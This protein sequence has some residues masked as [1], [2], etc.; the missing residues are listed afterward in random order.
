MTTA[1][2]LSRFRVIIHQHMIHRIIHDPNAKNFTDDQNEFQE[3]AK[4]YQSLQASADQNNEAR[5]KALEE[6]V[7]AGERAFKWEEAR[8]YRQELLELRHQ[9]L[10]PQSLKTLEVLETI[11][12]QKLYRYDADETWDFWPH[13]EHPFLTIAEAY[14]GNYGKDAPRYL[15]ARLRYMIRTTSPDEQFQ[16]YQENSNKLDPETHLVALGYLD[17]SGILGNKLRPVL[18]DLILG[19]FQDLKAPPERSIDLRYTIGATYEVFFNQRK[20]LCTLFDEAH[21]ITLRH[22]GEEH[23]QVCRWL[24]NM[25]DYELEHG[26]YGQGAIYAKRGAEIWLSFNE[27]LKAAYF[28]HRQGRMESR[29]NKPRRAISAFA[30]VFHYGNENLHRYAIYELEQIAA[31]PKGYRVRYLLQDPLSSD[32]AKE[33]LTKLSKYLD[34]LPTATELEEA[35]YN[36]FA[37]FMAYIKPLAEPDGGE[38]IYR[39]RLKAAAKADDPV[40]RLQSLS[41]LCDCL[42]AKEDYKPIKDLLYDEIARRALPGDAETYTDSFALQEKLLRRGTPEIVEAT[43]KFAVRFLEKMRALSPEDPKYVRGLNRVIG[44]LFDK[45]QLTYA[46]DLIEQVRRIAASFDSNPK[47]MDEVLSE[48]APYER[49]IKESS[50]H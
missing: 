36:R 41:D 42:L 21:Q 37:N 9:Y 28:F 33:A 40:S 46:I 11:C 31:H 12:D 25:L 47:E 35:N 1:N 20:L 4:A 23:P 13:E 8:Q 22:F 15:L 24:S 3:L 5:D 18:S 49:Y 50:D 7:A 39:A 44:E 2:L 48:V 16:W 43:Y 45:E 14:E 10:G 34:E 17:D 38:N 26:D 19:L 27:G 6:L 32:I 30:K 29:N